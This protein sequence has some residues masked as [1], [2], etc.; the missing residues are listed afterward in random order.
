MASFDA[1]ADEIPGDASLWD[2]G[3]YWYSVFPEEAFPV[4]EWWLRAAERQYLE[5]G[6]FENFWEGQITFP[7]PPKHRRHSNIMV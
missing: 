1:D 6:R 5:P 2:R 4:G 7:L 3:P